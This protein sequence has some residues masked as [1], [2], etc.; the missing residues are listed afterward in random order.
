M[1]VECVGASGLL[2]EEGQTV[3]TRLACVRVGRLC[4][5]RQEG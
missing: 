5:G 4:A 3:D 1:L 2:Y